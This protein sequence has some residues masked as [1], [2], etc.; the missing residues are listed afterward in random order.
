[1]SATNLI[2]GII[3]GGIGF[4][5]FIYGKK[6]ASWKPLAIGI[7]L[8]A[9]PYFVSNTIALYAIGGLLTLSL[10]FFHD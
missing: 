10:F 6:Q 4:V 1:M 9:Y 8:M 3:F 7:A 5:A 2:A